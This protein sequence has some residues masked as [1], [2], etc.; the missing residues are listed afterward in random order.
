VFE[1]KK[2]KLPEGFEQDAEKALDGAFG[3]TTKTDIAPDENQKN[4]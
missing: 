3:K 1:I 4:E 2:D